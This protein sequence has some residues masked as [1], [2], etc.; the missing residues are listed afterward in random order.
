VKKIGITSIALCIFFGI[1]MYQDVFPWDDEVTHK[2]LSEYAAITSVLSKNGGDYLKNLG[3]DTGLDEVL[4]WQDK[5]WTITKWLRYGAEREDYA[6]PLQMGYLNGRGR[7]FNHFHN[8]LKQYPWTEAGLDDWPFKGK[9]SI[10]WAQDGTY[11]GNFYEGNWSWQKTREYF[12]DALTSTKKTDREAN[13]AKTFRGLGHQIHL[14]Q[15]TAVPA[16]V[17]NDAH[18]DDA[19]FGKD[20]RFGSYYFETW[21]K[22]KIFDLTTMKSFAPFPVFPNLPF[23]VSHNN[24]APVTQLF[25]TDTY[26][27]LNASAGINQG[28]SEY[29]NANFYSNDTIFA[30]EIYSTGHRHYF[31]YPKKTSTDLQSYVNQNKLPETIISEDGVSDVGFWIKKERDGE[32]IEHF[33]KPSYLARA[34]LDETGDSVLYE[35]TFYRDDKCHEDYAKL[36]LPRAVGYSAGLLNYFFR[37]DIRLGYE[38]G[39]TPGYAIIN[40]SGEKM[41][42]EF[43]IYYDKAGDERIPLWAGRGTLEATIGDKTNTFDFIPPGDAKEPGKYIVVFKGKMGNEDGAVVGNVSGRT[44][45]ITPP[46]QFLYSIADA[47]QSDPYFTSI[48]AK[49]KN[50]NTS[51]AIQNGFIQAIAKYKTDI[52][53]ADFSYS[54]SAP[55]SISSL[56][57]DQATEFEFNF[58]NDPIPVDV[59]DLYLQFIFK[60]KIGNE[61]NAVAIGQKDISEPTPIDVFNNMD[62]ICIN[63]QWYVTGS[64][65]AYNALPSNAKWWDYWPHDLKDEYLKISPTNDN[66]DASPTNYTFYSL[67][68]EAGTLYRRFILCDYEFRHSGYGSMAKKDQNDNFIHDNVIK[69]GSG[70][71]GGVRNQEGYTSSFYLF[72]GV[73]MWGPGGIIVDGVSY[74]N[75]TDQ[76]YIKCEWDALRQ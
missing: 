3:F 45:E 33:L 12:F 8:A 72:R 48:K 42:G 28:L 68:I 13:F 1:F 50:A 41:E 24:L 59:T 74:P 30:A 52:D 63:G 39:D 22:T 75:Y 29:T 9:S 35:R 38:T 60:G 5:N 66:S 56:A 53:D 37:G 11:Q 16:H 14:L 23:S 32:S 6:G 47:D 61:N 20:R 15:D 62:R 27:G 71:G 54:M 57:S 51:E 17:R 10:L 25:D 2:D 4:A 67:L 31:P 55:Q 73:E 26:D 70:Q 44:L 36:L 40:N 18:P 65:E 34:V 7:S 58:S 69:K 76:N 21:A 64:Q 49:V 19:I 43:V 46:D